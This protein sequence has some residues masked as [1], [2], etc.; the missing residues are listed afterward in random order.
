M[1]IVLQRV[2]ACAQPGLPNPDKLGKPEYPVYL[3]LGVH[4]AAIRMHFVYQRSD[5]VG[6]RKARNTVT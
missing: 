2:D 6:G 1:T 3:L 4:T 5:D